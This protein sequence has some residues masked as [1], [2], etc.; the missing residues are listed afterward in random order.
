MIGFEQPAKPFNALN[1]C[2]VINVVFWLNDPAQ[3]LMNSFVVIILTILLQ[4]IFEL[5][6]G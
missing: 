2:I 1:F 6:N 4:D 5:L 3:R